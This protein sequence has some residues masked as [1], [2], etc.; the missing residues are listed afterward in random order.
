MWVDGDARAD[1]HVGFRGSLSVGSATTLKV[2][3]FASCPF[4]LFL[5]GKWIGEGPV[6]WATA[7][8]EF[9]VFEEKIDAGPHVLAVHAHYEGVQTRMMEAL[10]PLISCVAVGNAVALPVQWKATVLAGYAHSVPADQ[11]SV[12]LD[13]L[14]RYARNPS[15]LANERIR[16]L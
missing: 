10:P 9:Q 1:T 4:I 13:R 12:R 3:V 7:A 2:R 8:P 5:D 14:V 15:R 16:R 11:S 6:R